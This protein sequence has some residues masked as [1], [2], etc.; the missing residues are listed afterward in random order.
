[1]QESRKISIVIAI[2]R[3]DDSEAGNRKIKTMRRLAA[4]AA[5]CASARD[6]GRTGGRGR[7]GVPRWVVAV[8][9]RVAFA[10]PA[11]AA[12]TAAAAA[13]AAAAPP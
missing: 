10:P 13:A 9:V 1:M 3:P 11:A 2:R 4:V 8:P 7:R 12:A 5:V 6:R